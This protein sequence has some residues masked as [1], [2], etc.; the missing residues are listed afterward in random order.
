MTEKEN[1]K[2]LDSIFKLNEDY[3]ALYGICD[4]YN[5]YDNTF[6][7]KNLVND[8]YTIVLGD[9]NRDQITIAIK[10]H[11]IFNLKDEGEYYFNAL[12][13]WYED[14]HLDMIEGHWYV[15]YLEVELS[16][17]FLQRDRENSLSKIL[18][19]DFD[20]LF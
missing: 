18:P 16:Q 15:E 7:I 6:E 17:T 3:L 13:K 19:I 20:N 1:K 5:I 10:D 12:L 2:I 11:H 8:D 14:D 4:V 9:G